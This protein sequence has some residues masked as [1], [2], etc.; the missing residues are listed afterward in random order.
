MSITV[1]IPTHPQ[2][3]SNGMLDRAVRSVWRQELLPDVLIV[4]IDKHKQGAAIT[5]D[6]GLMKVETT[7]VAFL[8]SDDEF[9][10]DHLSKLLQ[11]AEETG[12]DYVYSWFAAAG[13]ADPFPEFYQKPWDD[14]N[15]HITTITTLVTT[16]LA[17]DIGFGE[18]LTPDEASV[19]DEDWR[20]TLGCIDRNAKITHLPERTWVWYQHGWNTG[21]HP[22]QGDATKPL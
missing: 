22:T 3:I 21:G 20:F 6:R 10:P 14:E 9:M 18:Y 11:C 13:H 2:R 12:S 17:Q 5:R 16:E 15:P 7:W 4:E 19:S 8:D 1:V